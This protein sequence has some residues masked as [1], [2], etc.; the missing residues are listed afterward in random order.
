MTP[1][2][3]TIR[4]AISLFALLGASDASGY[5]VVKDVS[6]RTAEFPSEQKFNTLD[7]YAPEGAQALPVVVYIHGGGWEAGDKS[8]VYAQPQLFTDNQMMY[9]SLNH[10]LS[11]SGART[12]YIFPTHPNDVADALAW[13]RANIANYGGDPQAII[14]TGHSSGAHL[15]AIVSVDSGISRREALASMPSRGPFC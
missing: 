3:N 13:I 5:T 7:V 2:R 10:R 6:Y 14:I 9:V 12:P 11:W 1:M 4:A 8:F 15:S